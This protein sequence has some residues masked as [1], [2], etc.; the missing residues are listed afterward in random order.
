MRNVIRTTL[1]ALVTG[2]LV[3]IAA[4]VASASPPVA[5]VSPVGTYGATVHFLHQQEFTDPLGVLS[6]HAF[7]FEDGPTGKWYVSGD[8][9]TLK[10]SGPH[11]VFLYSAEELDKNLGSRADP[12]TITLNGKPDGT[13]FALRGAPS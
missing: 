7:E 2:S 3:V 5:S 4:G 6:D 11:F 8:V 9:F 13:W 1:A 12:G 10:K